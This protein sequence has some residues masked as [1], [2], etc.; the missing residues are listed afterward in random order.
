MRPLKRRGYTLVEVMI[1]VVLTGLMAGLAYQAMTGSQRMTRSLG[2]RVD[3]QGSAR[4]A[5][6]YL[7]T[8]FHELSASDGDIITAGATAMKYRAMRWTGI[9]CT[10]LTVAG[11]NLRLTMLKS[12]LWGQRTPDAAL[13][14][15]LVYAENSA[16]TRQDDVWL[17]GGLVDTATVA[18]PNAAPGMRITFAI[19]AASGGNAAAQAGFTVNSPIRGFQHEEVSL[20]SNAGTNWFGHK[21]MD[22]G[23]TWTAVEALVGPLTATG[24]AFTY[25]DTLSV[26]TATLTDI[27]SV[28]VI[29]RSQSTDAANTSTGI[30][31]LR[32]SLITRIALRNNR[33][34]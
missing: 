4:S 19:S 17:V 13:D 30:G 29:V 1:A 20:Y 18:C 25:Y 24:L 9:S 23:G 5:M 16:A 14:S 34:F 33:R 32:D 3:A 8:A 27:A 31:N 7:S 11:G 6:L 26:V 21:T 22:A 2:A 12:Q 28:G 10:G 15:I